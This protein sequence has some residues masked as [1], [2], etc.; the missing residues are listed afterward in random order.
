MKC[1]ARATKELPWTEDPTGDIAHAHAIPEDARVCP[2]CFGDKRIT[3]DYR[4][5]KR[6]PRKGSGRQSAE[7]VRAYKREELNLDFLTALA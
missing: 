2:L 5:R 6:P 4:E 7:L 1:L 3:V